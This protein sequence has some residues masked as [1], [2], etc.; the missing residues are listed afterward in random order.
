LRREQSGL[1]ALLDACQNI[2]PVSDIALF[3]GI[4]QSFNDVPRTCP[5]PDGAFHWRDVS[6]SRSDHLNSPY[7]FLDAV[8]SQCGGCSR[9]Q[10]ANDGLQILK[11][12]HQCVQFA[13]DLFSLRPRIFDTV[14]VRVQFVKQ[15]DGERNDT[16]DGA[17]HFGH[18]GRT[19]SQKVG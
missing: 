15:L 2:F 1:Q 14:G 10:S 3:E 7:A 5:E 4:C 9:V 19:K 16:K 13:G 12:V 8:P 18:E 11:K 6:K 17:G